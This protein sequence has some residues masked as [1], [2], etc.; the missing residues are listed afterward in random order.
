MWVFRG[1]SL[2]SPRPVHGKQ[3]TQ[4]FA[5]KA[6][7]LDGCRPLFGC[8]HLWLSISFTPTEK[9]AAWYAFDFL[10]PYSHGLIVICQGSITFLWIS[11]LDMRNLFAQNVLKLLGWDSLLSQFQEIIYE[12]R[13]PLLKYRSWNSLLNFVK[14]K[15]RHQASASIAKVSSCNASPEKFKGF[16]CGEMMTEIS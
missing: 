7:R 15:Y 11:S 8:H 16:F 4:D 6:Q 13:L 1:V 5:D 3:S 2:L 9:K 10:Q 12:L 14:I